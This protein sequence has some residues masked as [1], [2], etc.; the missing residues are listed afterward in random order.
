[1]KRNLFFYSLPND[2]FLD[3]TKFKA[4]SDKKKLNVA[5]IMISVFNGV[6]N[7]AGKGENDGYQHFFP[8]PQCCPKASFLGLLKIRIVW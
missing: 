7:I 8:F 1:M 6:E 5:K 4:F 3:W 2:S